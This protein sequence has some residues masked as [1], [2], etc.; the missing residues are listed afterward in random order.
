MRLID[1]IRNHK[2]QDPVLRI[3]SFTSLQQLPNM[4]SDGEKQYGREVGS[5]SGWLYDLKEGDRSAVGKIWDRYFDRIVAFA[6]RKMGSVPRSV[7]DEEDF[8]IVAFAQFVEGAELGKFQRINDRADLWQI[9]SMIT[10]RRVLNA[11]RRLGT[12]RRE[13]EVEEIDQLLSASSDFLDGMNNDFN[14]LIQQLPERG[15]SIVRQKLMGFSNQEIASK[16]DMSVATVEREF[17]K[18]RERWAVLAE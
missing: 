7:Q 3:P 6:K 4:N 5:V 12:R 1:E 10:L 13:V 17:R 11:N 9:I 15:Q 18:I 2:T 14:D 16:L 8:A